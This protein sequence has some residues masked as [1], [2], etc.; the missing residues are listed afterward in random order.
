MDLSKYRESGAEIQRVNSLI[1]LLP[2]KP[3]DLTLL[4]VGARDGYLSDLLADRFRTVIALDIQKTDIRNDA[5]ISLQGD[6]TGL[7]FPDLSIDVVLCAEVLEHIPQKHLYRACS[8]LTRIT[9]NTLIIG[10]PFAQDLRIAQ[11]TCGTCGAHNPPWGHVNTFTEHD[12]TQL[13]PAMRHV[14]TD[15]VGKNRNTTNS[16]SVYFMN[17][18]GNPFGTYGQEETCIYCKRKLTPPT[19]MSAGQRTAA[20]IALFLNKIQSLSKATRPNWLHMSFQKF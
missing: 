7:P 16:L 14:S 18:A 10:V 5:V 19:A 8:E 20:W 3:R 6:V 4:D 12:L 1:Q 9:K 17:L 2:E 15:Y 13:F 11:T